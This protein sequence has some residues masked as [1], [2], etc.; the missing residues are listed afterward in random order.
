MSELISAR[1]FA[2]NTFERIKYMISAI[3]IQRTWRVREEKLNEP[4]EKE[5][6]MA[7]M[8]KENNT[9][10][11]PKDFIGS[12]T[13]V[14]VNRRQIHTTTIIPNWDKMIVRQ[15]KPDDILFSIFSFT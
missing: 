6:M 7:K 8:N 10:V 4:F 3:K 1:E 14:N 2:M 11:I 9:I 12:R 13:R 5:R 15:K